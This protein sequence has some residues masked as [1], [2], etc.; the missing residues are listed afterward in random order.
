MFD[1]G[2]RAAFGMTVGFTT[3]MFLFRRWPVRR[4][5]TF[6]GLGTGLGLNYS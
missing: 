3:S 5:F 6:F 2:F 1:I 4:F